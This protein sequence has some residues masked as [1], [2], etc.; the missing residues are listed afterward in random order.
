[1]FAQCN[2]LSKHAGEKFA[3]IP[4]RLSLSI[5]VVVIEKCLNYVYKKN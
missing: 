1:M 2:L 4:L 3:R 5:V